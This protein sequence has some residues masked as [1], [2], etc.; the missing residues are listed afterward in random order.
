MTKVIFRF[1]TEDFVNKNAADGI[2]HVIRVLDEYNV[3]GVLVIVG[4]FA[5]ALRDW[6]RPDIIEALK[7]HEIGIHSLAVPTHPLPEGY[8]EKGLLIRKT[9]AFATVFSFL[10]ARYGCPHRQAEAIGN[11]ARVPHKAFGKIYAQALLFFGEGERCARA[12]IGHR[13]NV[14]RR[15]K[16]IAFLPRFA[17]FIENESVDRQRIL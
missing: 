17:L 11:I 5:E 10:C 12:K 4:K 6:G 3:R 13:E 16:K 9:V 1:D 15:R 8:Q 7:R 14:T 2:L